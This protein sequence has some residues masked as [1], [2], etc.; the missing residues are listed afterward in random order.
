[1]VDLESIMK[2]LS[3]RQEY[4]LG[5]TPVHCS[6]PRDARV[7]K[8]RAVLWTSSTCW[9]VFDRQAETCTDAGTNSENLQTAT[10]DSNCTTVPPTYQI[11][12]AQFKNRSSVTI[13]TWRQFII[14]NATFIAFI[15]PR[16]W[17]IRALPNNG[18]LMVQGFE[19]TTL[20]S[21]HPF[22]TFWEV[23]GNQGPQRKPSTSC[24][25]GHVRHQHDLLHLPPLKAT[26]PR[27]VPVKQI[28]VNLS[29]M[30][31]PGQGHVVS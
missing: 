19:L 8:N 11:L 27:R 15:Y 24:G 3:W 17:G 7:Q 16:S 25:R 2:A 21:N 5:G 20:Q 14:I 22:S 4:T 18:S 23:G 1:M 31:Y 30:I 29:Q 9:L 28:Q 6:T 10:E 12:N 13:Q 26:F